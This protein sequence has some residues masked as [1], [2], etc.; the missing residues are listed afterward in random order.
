MSR[1]EY[2]AKSLGLANN[3]WVYGAY[4]KFLPY[5]PNPLGS[6]PKE[7]K[8]LICTHTFSDWGMPRELTAIEIDL[9]TLCQNTGHVDKNGV[10]IWEHD[11]LQYE[12]EQGS[13][14]KGEVVWN[15]DHA[16]FEL[17]VEE[18]NFSQTFPLL[19][20]KFLHSKFDKAEE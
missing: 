15:H 5:T 14:L 12:D 9:S 4:Y 10:A 18:G 7:Y 13:S 1:N 19:N 8:H 16:C 17:F 2:K 6:E 20:W 11:I 3:I